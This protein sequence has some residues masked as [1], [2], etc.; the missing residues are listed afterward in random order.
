MDHLLELDEQATAQLGRLAQ[1]REQ[2][3]EEMRKPATPALAR[4]LETADC[5]LLIGLS[6]LG[7]TDHLF[8]EQIAAF[9]PEDPT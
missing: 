4:A 2:L 6:Y 3:R 7:Y 9:P 5:Y 1:L 8:P